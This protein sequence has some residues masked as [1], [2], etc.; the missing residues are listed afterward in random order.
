M[1]AMRKGPNR[2][3]VARMAME[4]ATPNPSPDAMEG[5]AMALKAAADGSMRRA[6]LS[7]RRAVP[8]TGRDDMQ[9]RLLDMSRYGVGDEFGKQRAAQRQSNPNY[10]NTSFVETEGGAYQP[11]NEYLQDKW[12]RSMA[13]QRMRQSA[14]RRPGPAQR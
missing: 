2:A 9:T 4:R 10:G 1:P 6:A 5:R 14:M 13:A 8:A 7:S 12:D 11:L 3:M